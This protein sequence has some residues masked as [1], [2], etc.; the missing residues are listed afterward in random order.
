MDRLEQ[1]SQALPACHTSACVPAASTLEASGSPDNRSMG[2]LCAVV[3]AGG[4][5]PP[6]FAAVIKTD[7]K[8][9]APL[10]SQRLIDP[11]IDAVRGSDVFGLAVVGP[12]A[13]RAYCGDRVDRFIDSAPSG[14]ENIKRALR[15]FPDA[16]R[17]LFLT[18]DLPFIDAAGIVGFVGASIG[19]GMT[20]AL[21]P[22]SAYSDRFPGSPPHFV[23]FGK[24]SYANGSAFLIDQ[25]AVS[26]LERV[27]GSFF[28]ARKSLPRLAILLGVALS[29]R[30]AF[31]TLRIS[32]IER[33][34][35]KALGVSVRAIVSADPGL[36]FDI[37]EV[38]DWLYAQ[39]LVSLHG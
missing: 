5:V 27:A 1:F 24:T 32:D 7:I 35:G 4:L 33:R 3:T 12:P 31:R 34:A 28:S 29:L 17:I 21:A 9:L 2:N 14:V 36:C 16:D 37:D 13:V 6:E 18:S 20:M 25:H 23:S 38:A 39:R 19:Y 26:A 11:V 30:F 15:A 8:A 22:A 10:G